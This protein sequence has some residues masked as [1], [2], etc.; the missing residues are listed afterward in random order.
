MEF[1]LNPLLMSLGAIMFL[2]VAYAKYGEPKI[3]RTHARIACW[4]LPVGAALWPVFVGAFLV[5]MLVVGFLLLLAV[6]APAWLSANL[7]KLT[8][9]HSRSCS[10]S[11][12]ASL[13]FFW[14]S[15]LTSAT[16]S[17]LNRSPPRPG[18]APVLSTDP[19]YSKTA[20]RH[21]GGPLL[22]NDA[23]MIE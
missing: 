3:N 14:L 2:A 21:F 6:F 11:S 13:F 4:A 23:D 22:R 15:R 12:S 1:W 5:L 7:G 20:V 10:L 9:T 19:I 17:S 8:F 16:H 18:G